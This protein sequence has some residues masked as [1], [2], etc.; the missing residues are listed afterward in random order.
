MSSSPLA[1][2]QV[3]HQTG[4]RGRVADQQVKGAGPAQCDLSHEAC[5]DIP[6]ALTCNNKQKLLSLAENPLRDKGMAFLCEALKHPNCTLEK[7]MLR[8]CCLTCAS[9]DNIPVLLRSKSLSLLDLGSNHLEHYAVAFL[10]E[11]LKQPD[12]SIGQLWL[13]ACLLTSDSCKNTADVLICNEKLKIL[14][15]R[16][17]EVG[18]AGVK[19]LGEALK[20]P[21]CR[22][23]WSTNMSDQPRLLSRPHCCTHS[24]QNAEEPVPRLDYLGP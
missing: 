7:V 23:S 14:K 9:C 10:C 21:N 13:M 16:H 4:D 15:H 2:Y 17:N 6:S 19:Q 24:Q 1:G 22:V 12:C 18:D 11:A 8:Y 20:H 3:H 5:E